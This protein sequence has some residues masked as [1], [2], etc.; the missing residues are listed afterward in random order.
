MLHLQCVLM[1]HRDTLIEEKS[2]VFDWSVKSAKQCFNWLGKQVPEVAAIAGCNIVLSHPG[3]SFSTQCNYH[4]HYSSS[5]EGSI[6]K[7]SHLISFRSKG[8]TGTEKILKSVNIITLNW[9]VKCWIMYNSQ[10]GSLQPEKNI[11]KEIQTRH[12]FGNEIH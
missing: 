2:Y 8:L 7:V 4:S 11:L 9:N 6:N 10:C 3:I 12:I 1:Q 5:W